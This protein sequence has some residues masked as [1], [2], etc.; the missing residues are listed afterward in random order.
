LFWVRL[1][2]LADWIVLGWAE[3][4]DN[5][6]VLVEDLN[7]VK[8]VEEIQGEIG[9]KLYSLKGFTAYLQDPAKEY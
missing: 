5:E 7:V 6:E 2:D 4:V 9:F 8:V 1:P 3:L